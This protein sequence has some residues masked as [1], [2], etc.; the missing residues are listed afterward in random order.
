MTRS[1]NAEFH[2]ASCKSWQTQETAFG[3]WIRN[4]PRLD[5][6]DGYAVTDQDYWIHYYRTEHGRQFQLIMGV[7][8][9]TMGRDLS[10]SQKDTLH[11]INQ[12]MRNRRQ[13]PTKELKHQAGN[14]PAKVRSLMLGREVFLKA[15]G[16]HVL[17]FSHLGPEDSE[18]MT[19]DNK[20]INAERLTDILAFN[21]DPDTLNPIDLRNHHIPASRLNPQLPLEE[22]A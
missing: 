22:T 7:E 9:K 6:R 13:T 17:R 2:C 5:S 19:W 21:L 14:S 12:L 20:Q 18:W 4:N 8:I 11:I 10:N 3:R 16:M 15:Y 1:F